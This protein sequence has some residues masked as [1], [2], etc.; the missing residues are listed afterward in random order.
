MKVMLEA[1]KGRNPVRILMTGSS[2]DGCG[3]RDQ[4]VTMTRMKSAG[5]PLTGPAT[6]K[7]WYS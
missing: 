6:L 4:S 5:V 1:L 7:V 2:P 3:Y